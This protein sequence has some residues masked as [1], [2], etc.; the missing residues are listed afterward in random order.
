VDLNRKSVVGWGG[1][2]CVVCVS[3]I[4][5]LFVFLRVK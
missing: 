2:R 1:V 3:F 4:F 5:C